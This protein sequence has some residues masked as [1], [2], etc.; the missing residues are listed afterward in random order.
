MGYLSKN[1]A[2]FGLALALTMGASSIAM[3][4]AVLHRGNGDEI[5]TLDPHKST[6]VSGSWIQFDLFEGLMAPNA[7]GEPIPGVA[8]SYTVSDDGKTYTFKLRQNA[9]WSDGTPVTADDFVF[10]WLR[11]LDPKTASDYG[12]F[13]WPV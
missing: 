7:K 11:L 5:E 8:E 6:D 3:A 10:S 13:L 9:N 12:Y 4:Q 2:R 1:A